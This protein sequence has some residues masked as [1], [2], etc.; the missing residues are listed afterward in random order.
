MKMTDHMALLRKQMISINGY[1]PFVIS[2]CHICRMMFIG[3]NCDIKDVFADIAVTVNRE[4]G[5]KSD[6]TAAVT[7]E[8][9]TVNY[10][11]WTRQRQLLLTMYPRL[12]P[13]PVST[14]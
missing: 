1:P 10:S 12:E 6:R 13:T 4:C 3:Q 5:S 2:F 14:A 8:G 7:D 9:T 11:M